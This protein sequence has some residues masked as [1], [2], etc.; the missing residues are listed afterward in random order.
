[1][2]EIHRRR[3]ASSSYTVV[4]SSREERKTKEIILVITNAS[5]VI[6]LSKFSPLL[7]ENSIQKLVHG[8]DFS[9][10][11]LTDVTIDNDC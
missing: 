9:S 6:I 3:F 10:V 7:S 5:A 4:V 2:E 8:D 11:P 1:M